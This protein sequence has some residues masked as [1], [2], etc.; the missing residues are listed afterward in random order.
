MRLKAPAVKL[1]GV[2]VAAAALVAVIAIAVVF[3][4]R[5]SDTSPESGASFLTLARYVSVRD[6]ENS[7]W[8]YD[9]ARARNLAGIEAPGPDADRDAVRKYVEAL[10]AKTVTFGNPLSRLF[11]ALYGLAV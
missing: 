10:T 5:S 3:M 6:A 9:Y 7:V 2:L 11:V 1:K 8:F 4:P